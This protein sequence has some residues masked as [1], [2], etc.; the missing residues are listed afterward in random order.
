MCKESTLQDLLRSSSHAH[1]RQPSM[2]ALQLPSPRC[3]KQKWRG[4]APASQEETAPT[5][6]QPPRCSVRF[7]AGSCLRLFRRPPPAAP[8]D[9]HPA[10]AAAFPAPTAR[11]DHQGCPGA[12]WH[13]TGGAENWRQTSGEIWGRAIARSR[14]WPPG[15]SHVSVW[16]LP[17]LFT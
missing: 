6:A 1:A 5:G 2:R 9:S 12:G 8:S 11:F 4:I 10:A 13:D 14:S 15:R 17:L 3:A 16:S 7:P